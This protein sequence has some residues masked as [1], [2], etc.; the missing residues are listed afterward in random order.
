LSSSAKVED[1]P[2]RAGDPVP[3]IMNFWI[4]GSSPK[5][6]EKKFTKQSERNSG[7]TSKELI[8]TAMIDNNNFRRQ[9]E[10]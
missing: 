7:M 6:T 5:M 9:N 4:S 3:T 8:L 1:A 10:L 2:W